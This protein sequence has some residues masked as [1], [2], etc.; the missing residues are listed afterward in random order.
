MNRQKHR[1][2]RW[3]AGALV[4][5][6]IAAVLPLAVTVPVAKADVSHTEI[7]GSGS[8]WAYNAVE[9]WIADEQSA[10]LKVVFTG[11]GSAQGRKDFANG[12]T[13]YAVSDIG[14]LGTD[15]VTGVSDTSQGRAF[16]YLPIVAGGTSFPYQIRAHGQLVT[17]LRLSGATLS[18]I[19]T[20]QITNWDDPA[21]T[22]DNNGEALPNLPIIPVV[23][24]EG[25]GSTA[26]FTK[27]LAQEFP[28]Q[29]SNF[30][31]NSS[32]TEYWPPDKGSQISQN[33]SDGV[34]N[35]VTSAAGNGSIGYDEYSYALQKQYP[36]ARIENTSGYFAAPTQY[37][38]AVALTQAIINN[39][40]NSQDYLLQ[41]LRNV[42]GYSD[43][44]TYP[45]SS[46]SYAIIPTSSTDVRMTTAKRQTL[47]DY[48]TYSVCQGQA[49]M[50][51]IGYSPLPGNLVQGSFDQIAKL[52]TADSGVVLQHDTISECNNPTFDPSEPSSVNR[53]AQIAPMPPACAKAGAGPCMNGEDLINGNP[54]NNRPTKSGGTP[55]G[56]ETKTTAGTKSGTS[57]TGSRS[58]GTSKST[59][60]SGSNGS[61]RTATMTGTSPTG[62]SGSPGAPTIDPITGQVIPGTGGT[63]PDGSQSG[64][65]SSAYGNAAN[66]SAV[67][68]T[69]RMGTFLAVLALLLLVLLVSIPP[70][71]VQRYRLRQRS[72]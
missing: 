26:Q 18:A 43:A 22:A 2:A 45:L 67:T 47:A 31:G 61:S 54:V 35:F 39:D 16:A 10:G 21:I 9:Q 42:Y 29:W 8:T 46:Y 30:S 37:N 25:A 23:H 34:M 64:S 15:P 49:E 19:F 52:G 12:T 50:G 38:V 13:D 7:D 20:N 44:R 48:L 28:S 59:G 5:L 71:V 56:T 1:S 36:V 51:P 66:I 3:K 24:S 17:S 4:S 63:N 6:V 32:F 62:S 11:T 53:L 72:S 27:Y 58:N 65:G 33:G 40:P 60:A 41:D 14:Y 70:I 69:S 55:T 68:G 57:P